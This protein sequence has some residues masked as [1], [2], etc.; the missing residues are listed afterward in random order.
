MERII[1]N[2]IDVRVIEPK[3][4]HM[5]IFERFDELN[6]GE[7]LLIINDHDPKPL[8]Y[9]LLAERGKYL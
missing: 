3:Y 5:R 2:S 6:K 4:K 9:Q 1:E 8:Y 7:S